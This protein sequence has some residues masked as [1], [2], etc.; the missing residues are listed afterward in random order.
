LKI[1][2]ID[3][4]ADGRFFIGRTVARKFPSVVIVECQNRESAEREAQDPNLSAIICHK[5]L[6]ISGPE[7]VSNLRKLRPTLPIILVSNVDRDAE[8]VAAG[9]DRFLPFEEWLRI[10]TVLQELLTERP[11]VPGT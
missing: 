3:T 10:G 5:P 4:D 1:L 2:V 7:M 9:A 8:A 6:E 11:D